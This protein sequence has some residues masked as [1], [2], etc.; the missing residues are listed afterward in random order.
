MPY[1]LPVLLFEVVSLFV[2]LGLPQREHQ[3]MDFARILPW[4]FSAHSE[5]EDGVLITMTLKESAQTQ[6][7][8]SVIARFKL[9]DT[10]EIELESYGDYEATAALHSY[11]NV[12]DIDKV[13]ITGLGGHYI[14]TV[15]D[16]E[17]YTDETAP[18]L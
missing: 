10:C 8:A 13:S 6:K 15:A 14:D 11:F 7:L 12:S 17:V 1:L 16:K 3:A 4:E 2:G 5:Q 18:T 9:G